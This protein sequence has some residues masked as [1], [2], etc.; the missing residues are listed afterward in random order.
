[1]RYEYIIF[2]GPES[3]SAFFSEIPLPHIQVGNQLHLESHDHSPKPG[4]PLPTIERID[5][6]VFAPS[7]H[8]PMQLVRV[9]VILSS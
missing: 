4:M 1:M 5:V 7:A 3:S 8:Q 6:H 9:S 2:H